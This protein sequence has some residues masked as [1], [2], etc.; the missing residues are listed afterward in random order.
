LDI[1]G[2]DSIDRDFSGRSPERLNDGKMRLN[3]RL[4]KLPVKGR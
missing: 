4:G 3:T 2:T 1:I